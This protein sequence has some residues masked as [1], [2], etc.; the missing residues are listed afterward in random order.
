MK[1]RDAVRLP[2]ADVVLA[3]GSDAQLF[4]LAGWAG[5]AG[6]LLWCIQPVIVALAAADPGLDGLP[7]W[8]AFAS[9]PWV[10]PLEAVVFSGIGVSRLILVLAVWAMVRQAGRGRSTVVQAGHVMGVAGAVTWLL[11]AGLTVAE[12]TS[13]GASLP[14]AA[15]DPGLQRGL[16]QGLAIVLTGYLGTFAVTAAVWT[17]L[18]VTEGRRAGVV[19]MPVVVVNWL[20]VAAFGFSLLMPFSAPW[21]MVGFVLQTLVLGVTFLVRSR[22]V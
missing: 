21:G 11:V 14:V 19:G 7:D 10:G 4:R 13:V 18:L 22:R 6:F 20:F 2:Q 17:V 3:A 16:L 5:V 1:E 8:E 15:P 12:F 9:R